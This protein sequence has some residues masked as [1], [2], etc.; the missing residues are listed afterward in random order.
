MQVVRSI[1][2][3][4]DTTTA[5]RKILRLW[6]GY[7]SPTPMFGRVWSNGHIHWCILVD[8]KWTNREN[9]ILSVLNFLS[10]LVHKEMDRSIMDKTITSYTD[11]IR[12]DK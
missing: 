4:G 2:D 11:V 5:G 12:D 9:S 1:A 3:S 6:L 7:G 8:S 10:H